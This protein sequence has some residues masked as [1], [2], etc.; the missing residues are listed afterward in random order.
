[1]SIFE[2]CWMEHLSTNLLF[3]KSDESGKECLNIIYLLMFP[4]G[5]VSKILL[6]QIHSYTKRKQAIQI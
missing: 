1:M 4:N 5:K 2:E 6:H 3:M